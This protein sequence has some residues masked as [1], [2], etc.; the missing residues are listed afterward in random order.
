M[1]AW[2]NLSHSIYDE[3][4][5]SSTSA[6]KQVALAALANVPGA[7]Q[8]IENHFNRGALKIPYSFPTKPAINQKFHHVIGEGVQQYL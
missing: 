4:K 8:I 6:K 1:H 7:K 3:P 5:V 2:N